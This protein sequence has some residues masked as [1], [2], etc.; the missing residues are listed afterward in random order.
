MLKRKGNPFNPHHTHSQ[1]YTMK[2]KLNKYQ[3]QRS[4]TNLKE[5]FNMYDKKIEQ[6][7]EKKG[8]KNDK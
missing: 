2:K 5:L 3:H 6:K 4:N 7:K 8:E 1:R